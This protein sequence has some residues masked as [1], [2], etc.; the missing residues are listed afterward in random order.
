MKGGD[1]RRGSQ[2]HRYM[3]PVMVKHAY[4]IHREKPCPPKNSKKIT[5][6]VPHGLLIGATQATGEGITPT[7]RRGLELVA[8]SGAYTHLRSLKGKVKIW[9]N[10][11]KLRQDR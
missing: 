8:A 3:T 5:L 9:F 4:Q 7:I 10:L 2:T 6:Q 1:S 11:K